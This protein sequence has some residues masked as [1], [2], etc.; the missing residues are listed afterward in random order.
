MGPGVNPVNEGSHGVGMSPI[1][2]ALSSRYVDGAEIYASVT[3]LAADSQQTSSSGARRPASADSLDRSQ[4]P[5][6][7]SR[8]ALPEKT[9]HATRGCQSVRC[10]GPECQ[11]RLNPATWPRRTYR[12]MTS[13]DAVIRLRRCWASWCRP[14]TAS[15]SPG[16]PPGVRTG[17]YS[18]RIRSSSGMSPVSVT[19]VAGTPAG[20]VGRVTRWCTGRR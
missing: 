15:G 18:A 20:I 11:E 1:V 9:A 13:R 4:V 16:R 17:T 5:W 8:F 2:V 3:D 19:A 10:S 14:R 6:Q 12:R 7:V